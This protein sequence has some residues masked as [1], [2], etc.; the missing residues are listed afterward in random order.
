[1]QRSVG[2]LIGDRHDGLVLPPFHCQIQGGGI[3]AVQIQITAEVRL[4]VGDD[5]GDEFADQVGTGFRLGKIQNFFQSRF[6]FLLFRLLQLDDAVLGLLF[7][8][9]SQL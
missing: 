1:M 4:A 5:L 8:F 7:I 3:L 9:G 6:D 2:L